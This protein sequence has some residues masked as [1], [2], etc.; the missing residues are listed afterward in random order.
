[1]V[2]AAVSR[3]RWISL[4]CAVLIGLGVCLEARLQPEIGELLKG[5]ILPL[6]WL[7]VVLVSL[8]INTV[9]RYRL[10]SPLAILNLGLV[11]EIV[12]AAAISF[13]E[14]AVPA[15]P[16]SPVLGVSKVAVWIGVVGLLIPNKPWIKFVTALA[17]ASTWPLAY[18]LN[19]HLYGYDPLP[20]NRLLDVDPSCHT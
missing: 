15:S 16:D 10:L 17:S 8:G 19:L 11:F 18:V 1:M 12:V 2:E 7:F 3:L 4:T 13:S 20:W 9:Q 14:T 6:V 5:P